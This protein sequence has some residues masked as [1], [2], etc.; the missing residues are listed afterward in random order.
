MA[1]RKKQKKLPR[2]NRTGLA[3]AP[4]EKGFEAVQSYFQ[5]EVS[6]ADISKVLKTFIRSKLKN[7]INKDYVLAC[8][9]YKFTAVPYQAATAFW[10]THT[11]REDDD[12]RS[13]TYSD[14]LSK[15]LSQLIAMG[16]DIYFEK[17]A[18]LKNE[19]LIFPGRD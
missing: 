16:K 6:N 10:L 1:M 7:S 3:A 18:K 13:R 4:L 11:T 17:Q 8:P 12:Y 9:E 15:Y 2:R 19:D 14:A 5:T